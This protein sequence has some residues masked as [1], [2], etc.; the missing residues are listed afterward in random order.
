MIPVGKDNKGSIDLNNMQIGK[1]LRINNLI[2]CYVSHEETYM[3]LFN[4]N[5]KDKLKTYMTGHSLNQ[6]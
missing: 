6:L 4:M 5:F 3:D 2:K 1:S